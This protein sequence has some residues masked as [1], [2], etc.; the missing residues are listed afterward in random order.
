MLDLK[1]SSPPLRTKDGSIRVAFVRQVTR[2]IDAA[3]VA[4]LRGLVGDLHEADLG[5]V[6]EALETASVHAWS[7]C[8]ASTSISP[9]SP[10]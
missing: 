9:R 5:A 1:T 10:K 7:S 3:D 8:S 6:L 2:A 4:A